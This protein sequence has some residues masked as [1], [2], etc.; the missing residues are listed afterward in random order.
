MKIDD[1]LLTKLETLSAL[2]VKDN[3]REEVVKQLSGILSFVE[4]LNELELQNEDASFTVLKGG[5]LLR[6]DEAKKNG[7]VVDIILENTPKKEGRFFEVPSII[8]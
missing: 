2:K 6:A 7:E 8:E 1:N 4:N 3:K 5:T